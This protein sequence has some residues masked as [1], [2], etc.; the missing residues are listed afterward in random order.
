M[1][2]VAVWIIEKSSNFGCNLTDFDQI[3]HGDA[4][5]T[6]WAVR[7]LKMSN[8]KN[9][10]WR[11][12]PFCKI[13][14]S[15]HHSNGSTDRNEIW[16]GYAY[17]FPPPT[18]WPLKFWKFKKPRR[19]T[20]SIFKNQKIVIFHQRFDGSSRKLVLGHTLTALNVSTVENLKI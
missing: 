9:P 15:S 10:R 14:K 13:E 7:P 5:R 18:C 1:A 8:F 11:R 2:S 6:S 3:W 4:I 12:T 19:R 17:S 16:Y 20:A